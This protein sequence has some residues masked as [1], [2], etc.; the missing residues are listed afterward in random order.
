MLKISLAVLA[1]I[2]MMTKELQAGEKSLYDFLWLDPDKKVYVLQ[3]KLFKK[4][5]TFYADVGYMSNFT[6]KFQ[7]TTGFTVRT[8]FYLHEEWGIELMMN[9]YSNSN[10]DEFRNV[11]SLNGGEP[12]IR[13]LNSSYGALAI[14]SPFYGKINTFNRIFYFDWSFGAGLAK[15]DA[16]SNLKSVVNEDVK[17]TFKKESYTGAIL[18]TNFKFHLTE[19]VHLGVEYMN[20]Y[21]QAPGPRNPKSDKLRTNTDVI[22]SVGFSF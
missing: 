13:R 5:H 18:K 19:N 10:N 8:G 12:F 2:L 15:I 9:T 4:E 3:N 11:Q 7:T 22:L 20:T 17:T 16:E 1:L 6:S 14:W 21:Y